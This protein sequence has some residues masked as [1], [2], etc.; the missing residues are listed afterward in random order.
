MFARNKLSRSS[1]L[2]APKV[3]ITNP[4][5]ATKVALSLKHQVAKPAAPRRTLRVATLTEMSRTV[6]MTE[7]AHV[8]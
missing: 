8:R 4:T 2:S 5:L 3:D 7:A 1:A 6:T